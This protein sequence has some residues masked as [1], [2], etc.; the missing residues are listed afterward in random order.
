M[1]TIGSSH[2][3][4]WYRNSILDHIGKGSH[5]NRFG[6]RILRLDHIE[7]KNLLILV[8]DAGFQG[9]SNPSLEAGF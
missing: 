7:K 9:T 5:S 3:S 2:L 1:P 4:R 8:L 6:C